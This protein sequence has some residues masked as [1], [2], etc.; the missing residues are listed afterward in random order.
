MFGRRF[1]LFKLLGF[2][3]RV[4]ASW[5]ILAFLIVWSLAKGVFPLHFKG[6]PPGIY[7]WMG[8]AGALGLFLSI[9]FHEL[10][11]SLVATRFGIPMKGI[12]LFIFGGVAEMDEEPP[13]AKAEFL[14]AA[15]GPL[16]SIVLALVF[17][18]IFFFGEQGGWPV[19][20]TGVIGYLSWINAILAVFNLVPAFPLDGGR[21]LR[22]ALWRWKENLR[23]ATRVS[24]RI[25][26]GFGIL[27][28]ML[29]IFSVFQGDFIGGIWWFMIGLFLRNAAQM[30]YQQLLTRRAL[31]GERVGRFMVRDP[32]TV[33]AHISL[34]E[35]VRDYVYRYHFK[36]FP[37]VSGETLKGSVSVRQVAAIER[38]EWNRHTVGEIAAPCSPDAA[39]RP[40]DDAL[41]ALSVMSRT[42]NSR[43]MVV[44]GDRL[45]GII[46]LKD[47]L[48]FLSLKLE[49]HDL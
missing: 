24:S 49:L 26:S 9:V 42:G 19:P 21:V 2:E 22:S 17:Y 23:W 37:V 47:L 7:W 30:S 39:V 13:S 46:A 43:L 32:V 6:L 29:G 35:F 38:E 28:V 16:S 3:V 20:L 44:E 27:L 8:V 34:E 33:P 45:A 25:G 11:H 41:K 15:A 4:D 18:G 31:E 40:E 5:L 1:T 14:M 48:Q 10:C 36:M 12:T